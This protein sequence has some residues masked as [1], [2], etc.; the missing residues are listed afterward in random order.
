MPAKKY[1]PEKELFNTRHHR[2][3]GR[4]IDKVFSSERSARKSQDQKNSNGGNAWIIVIL[5][6]VVIS[7]VIKKLSH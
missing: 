2:Q 6:I 3:M 1:K 4:N 7:L 5:L